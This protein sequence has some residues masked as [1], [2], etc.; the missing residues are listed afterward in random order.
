MKFSDL[1]SCPEIEKKMN[2]TDHIEEFKYSPEI[3]EK[4]KAYSIHKVFDEGEIILREDSSI[5]FIPLVVSGS[6]K[7]TRTEEDG[8]EILLYY[9]GVGESCVMSILGGIHQETSK[10]KAIA[11]EKTEVLLVPVFR[12][13]MLLSEHPEWLKYFF[14]IYHERFTELLDVVNA[15]AFRK[16]D[17]RLLMLLQKKNEFTGSNVLSVTHE[18]LANELGTS[19]VVV[20]RLLKQMQEENLVILGRNKITL[21][22]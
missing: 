12:M 8:R 6:L 14:R 1:V 10:V 13:T 9:L 16:M 20:S 21:I 3:W 19:R 18:Q 2:L 4:L 7:I 22:T 17:E 11:E 5:Q 15:I